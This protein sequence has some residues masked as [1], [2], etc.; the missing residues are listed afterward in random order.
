M[1]HGITCSEACGTFLDQGLNPCLQH[2]QVDS[3]PLS[4]LGCPILIL[5]LLLEIKNKCIPAWTESSVFKYSYHV[6]LSISSFFLELF[7]H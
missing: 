2:W 1:A 6:C 7:L 3:V 5:D 4:H